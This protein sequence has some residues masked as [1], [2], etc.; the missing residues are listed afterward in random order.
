[1]DYAGPNLDGWFPIGWHPRLNAGVSQN[2][3]R[4]KDH[5]RNPSG[6]PGGGER[7]NDQHLALAEKRKGGGDQRMTRVDTEQRKPY[8]EFPICYGI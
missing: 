4:S 2:F 5:R 6:W 8:L 3:K 7:A 1:M